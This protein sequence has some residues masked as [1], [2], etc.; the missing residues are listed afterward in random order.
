MFDKTRSGRIDV[1]GFSALMRFIQQ[2]KNLFQQYDRDQSG[3]ISFSELQ[4]G[5]RGTETQ[6]WPL[7]SS[8]GTTVWLCLLFISS[9]ARRLLLAPSLQQG[10][11]F[12]SSWVPP[13][14]P[15]PQFMPVAALAHAGLA[16]PAVPELALNCSMGQEMRGHGRVSTQT[17]FLK[18]TPNS[19]S[20][21]YVAKACFLGG[22]HGC[23]CLMEGKNVWNLCLG[24]ISLVRESCEPNGA[25]GD[26]GGVPAHGRE[27]RATLPPSGRV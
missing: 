2:W 27:V 18:E 20:K 23:V 25:V 24:L 4:Q 17:S 14:Q 8:L 16:K 12:L 22:A 10:W 9:P 15:W 26:R 21:W 6:T 3:S 7:P 1:Y 11:V 19:S 5:G 13:T